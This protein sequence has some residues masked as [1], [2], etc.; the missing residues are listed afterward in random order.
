MIKTLFF[1]LD[2]TLYSF[3]GTELEIKSEMKALEI[4]GLQQEY[5][6][7]MEIKKELTKGQDI[8]Q[9]DRRKWFI[10]LLK[11]KGINE[12]KAEEMNNTYWETLLSGI[13][14]FYDFKQIEKELRKK[15]KIGIITDGIKEYQLQRFK[16]LGIEEFDY[17]ITSYESGAEKPNSLIFQKALEM[18]KCLPEEAIMIGDNPKRD[19]EGAKKVGMKTIR[20]KR[21]YYAKETSNADYEIENYEELLPIL[22]KI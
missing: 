17:F 19:L 14:L 5:T 6:R 20:L 3:K 2:D 11:E 9:E 12:E 10:V 7:F 13:E 16:A 15:Y 8:E 21:G 22:E 18:A 1:D 4:T